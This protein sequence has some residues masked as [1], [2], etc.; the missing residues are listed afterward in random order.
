MSR[1]TRGKL[2]RRR[3]ILAAARKLF[4]THGYNGTTPQDI[5][6]EA[7]VAYGTFYDNFASK[8][9][10]FAAFAQEIDYEVNQALRWHLPPASSIPRRPQE[11]LYALLKATFDYSVA[12]PGVLKAILS[13]DAVL[14][15]GHH[16]D[17]T[18]I[19]GATGWINRLD[20]WRQIGYASEDYNITYLGDMMA[21]MIRLGDALIAKHPKNADEIVENIT[22]FMVR[23]LGP[24]E[25]D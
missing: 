11:F 17:G 22:R 8:Q 3:V 23:A 10:C 21:G 1:A 4:A 24:K 5:V 15:D 19:Y 6:R 14:I 13:E 18:I 16:D 12:N 2:Q 9:E 25:G 7:D 20:K